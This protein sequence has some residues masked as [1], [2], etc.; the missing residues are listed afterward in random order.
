MLDSLM[1]GFVVVWGGV[2][3]ACG[4]RRYCALYLSH[5]SSSL[6]FME[7]ESASEP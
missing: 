4:I 2:D 1:G 3:F 5:C 6:V 7:G